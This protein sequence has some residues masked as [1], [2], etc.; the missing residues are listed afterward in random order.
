M[1]KKGQKPNKKTLEINYRGVSVANV[2][3][4]SGTWA[5]NFRARIK[6]GHVKQTH[7]GYFQT[8]EE[9]AA[10]YN[11]A[12]KKVFRSEKKAIAN[13]YWNKLD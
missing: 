7:L 11:K 3:Y 12:A 13:S 10:A 1:A 5:Y 6:V 2:R 9:A 8:P 4:V